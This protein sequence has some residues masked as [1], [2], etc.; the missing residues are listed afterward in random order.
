MPEKNGQ[1]YQ[2]IS[3]FEAES[4]EVAVFDKPIDTQFATMLE[5]YMSGV[6]FLRVDSDVAD[7]LKG[8]GEII[9]NEA[10]TE[11]FKDVAGERVAVKLERLKNDTV[12]AILNVSEES[13]RMEEM[14]RFYNMSDTSAFP[15]ESSLV[16]NTAS[17]LLAKIEA[18]MESDPE[19]AKRMAS[20]VYKVSLLSQKKF[21]GDEMKEFLEDSFEL[22]MNI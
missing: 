2:S 20:Y 17:P 5:Q 3:M 4:I 19:K 14:M 21:S 9:E 8:D 15:T 12:P 11:L 6:K 16:L 1:A 18:T 22:L 13:R 7:A 10:L